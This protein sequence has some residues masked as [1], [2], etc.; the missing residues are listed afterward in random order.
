MEEHRQSLEAAE[1]GKRTEVAEGTEAPLEVEDKTHEAMERVQTELEEM[2]D[3]YV[4]LYAEFEN[5][6]KKVLRDKEELIRFSNESLVRELLAVVDS[7]EMALKHSAEGG[8][9]AVAA[10]KAGVENTLREMHRILDKF[11]LKA[12][13]ALGR[14]FDPVFHHAMSQIEK[15]DVEANTVIEELRKGYIYRE[16]VLRPSLVV[17]SRKSENLN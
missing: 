11:G 9:K 15:N 14:P 4:R 10:L 6:K 13:D 5:Y 7:L 12:I 2:K 1:A 3:K 17:V 8:P 16:K